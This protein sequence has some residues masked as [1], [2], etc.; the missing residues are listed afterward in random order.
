MI[1][2]GEKTRLKGDFSG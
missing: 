2:K 1:N